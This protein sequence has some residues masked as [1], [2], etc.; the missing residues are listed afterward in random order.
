MSPLDGGISLRVKATVT[1]PFTALT[2]DHHGPG[3][4]HQIKQYSSDSKLHHHRPPDHQ[5]A[6]NEMVDGGSTLFLSHILFLV[7]LSSF[8]FKPETLVSELHFIFT[9]PQP[10]GWR[11]GS[12]EK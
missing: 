8:L 7:F 6:R 10:E 4:P 1:V 5:W 9:V 12:E 2:P 3:T 11:G